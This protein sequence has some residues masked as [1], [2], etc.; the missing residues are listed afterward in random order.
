[1]P[2]PQA[3]VSPPTTGLQVGKPRSKKRPGKTEWVWQQLTKVAVPR[4]ARGEED[5][6][7]MDMEYE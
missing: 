2:D 5:G 3:L 7:F 4:A 1:L 6:G